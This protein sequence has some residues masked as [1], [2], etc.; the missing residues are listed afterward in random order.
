MRNIMMLMKIIHVSKI[1]NFIYANVINAK[2]L[3]AINYSVQV[4]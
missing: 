1:S 4:Q 2:F 3:L